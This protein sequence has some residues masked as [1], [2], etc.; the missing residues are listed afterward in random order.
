MLRNRPLMVIISFS[1]QLVDIRREIFQV[2]T[3]NRCVST[4][5]FF[6][7]AAIFAYKGALLVFGIFL[8]WSTRNIRITQ[9][10][11]SKGFT[12]HLKALSVI[13]NSKVHFFPNPQIFSIFRENF[14]VINYL[15]NNSPGNSIFL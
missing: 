1:F 3:L 4:H 13:L 11:D 14:T 8:A 5:D 7:V 12:E 6:F 2:K 10:N 15:C 9:L